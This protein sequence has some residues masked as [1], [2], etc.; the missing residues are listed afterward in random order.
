MLPTRTCRGWIVPVE[1]VPGERTPNLTKLRRWGC[2]AYVLIS[3]A[4]CR[5]DWEGKAMVGDVIGYSKTK[6]FISEHPIGDT[7]VTPVHVLLM[8]LS[9]KNLRTI[10]FRKLDEA[11]MKVHPEE[12][13]VRDFD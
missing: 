12:R 6:A 9:Q 5:K 4:N 1:C 10:Y 7:V 3:K 8:R 2:K 13:Q 11:T